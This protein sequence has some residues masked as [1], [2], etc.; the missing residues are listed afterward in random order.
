M[1]QEDVSTAEAILGRSLGSPV[2]L[3]VVQE[4]RVGRVARCVMVG[5]G[6]A[7]VVVKAAGDRLDGSYR[8]VDTLH[9]EQAA[10]VLLDRLA[11][12]LAPRL[13]GS[14][15]TTGVLVLEDLGD[16][17]SLASYLLG[18]DAS[19]AREAAID[20]AANLGFLHAAT[21]GYAEEYEA[22]RSKLSEIDAR[23]SRV[24]LRGMNI[25][26]RVADLPALLAAHDLPL[27]HPFAMGELR[28]VLDRLAE[29]TEFLALSSGDPCP[30]NQR[31]MRSGTRFFDFEAAVFRHAL[32]DAAHN[33]LPF[34]NCWCWRALPP[35]VVVAMEVAYRRELGRG[36]PAAL[37]DR[38]FAY[39]ITLTM[40][41][42]LVWT[43]HRR[44]STAADDELVRNRL[45]VTL[46]AFMAAAVQSAD[47]PEL[48]AW[49]LSVL[50]VIAARWPAA[51]A[52]T[53]PAFGG[54]V[55]ELGR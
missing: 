48:T 55:F 9:N 14:E 5:S 1:Q 24:T 50:E 37:D 36:C 38:R 41:A 53:Y 51:P 45:V 12:G 10:L 52:P 47:L 8:G 15:P 25:E 2:R 26:H 32:I 20:F 11:P 3:R 44:L 39:E 42:W 7:S 4:F 35:D 19:A 27:P 40:A 29:P 21:I 23:A 13:L 28:V 22:L 46:R 30:D 49:A 31:I 18:D 43:L 17:P 33:R 54:P 34:P 6:S 16:G